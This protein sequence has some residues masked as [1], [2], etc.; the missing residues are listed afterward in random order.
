MPQCPS[1]GSPLDQDFGM[2]TCGDCG[3]VLMI[4]I[5]GQVVMGGEAPTESD[6][7]DDGENTD[8]PSESAFFDSPVESDILSITDDV[9]ANESDGNPFQASSEQANMGWDQESSISDNEVELDEFE[10]KSLEDPQEDFDSQSSLGN[11]ELLQDADPEQENS[12][13]NNAFFEDSEVFGGS[14]EQ[15]DVSEEEDLGIASAPDKKPLDVT[16]FA[17]SEASSLEGGEFLYEL[18]ISGLDSKDLRDVLKAVLMDEKLKL[19]YNGIMKK[20]SQGQVKI[21]G[22]NPV[23][24]KRIVEQLQY[25][26]LK[27]KWRQSRVTVESQVKEN[28]EEVSHDL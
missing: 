8:F 16:D 19:N 23:K 15:Q 22:L 20:I 28:P 9:L 7:Q 2:V 25:F 21:E 11:N 13:G 27:I 3:A 24:A 14:G 18:R 10:D 6:N 17:N 1:C 12:L 4:N 26:D 5:N